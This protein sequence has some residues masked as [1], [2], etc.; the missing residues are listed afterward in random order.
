MPILVLILIMSAQL[1]GG[2][3]TVDYT[4]A[5]PDP[6]SHVFHVSATFDGL[7]PSELLVIAASRRTFAVMTMLGGEFG[8]RGRIGVLPVLLS[9]RGI[10]ATRMPVLNTRERVLVE[11]ALE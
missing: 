1:R 7:D 6:A 2:P 8:A 5:M 3:R 4:L 11:N 10:A 9:A